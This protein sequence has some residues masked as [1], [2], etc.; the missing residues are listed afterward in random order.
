MQQRLSLVELAQKIESEHRGK[1]D[2]VENT[3]KIEIEKR[4][5]GFD[6]NVDGGHF[7]IRKEAHQQIDGRLHVP[8]GWGNEWREKNGQN[9]AD[10]VNGQ[11]QDAPEVRMI[12]TI[13]G[14]TRAFLSNRYQRIE[15]EEIASVVLPIFRDI[16]DIQ[17]VSAEIT[18]KRLYIQAVTPRVHGDVKVGDRVQAGVTISNSEIGHGAVSIAPLVYRLVCLNGMIIPDKRFRA[19]HVGRKLIDNEALYADDTRQAD[20]KAVLLKVRDNVRAALDESVFATQVAK[21]TAL[22]EGRIEG[23]PVKAI[24][25]LAQKV[26]LDEDDRFSILR[27]LINGGDSSPWGIVNA[28]TSLANTEE[29]Y[30]RSIELETAGGVLLDLPKAEW[31]RVLQAN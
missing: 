6:L 23:D 3:E 27:E 20:D 29:D 10:F 15:N 28:V 17:I 14:E 7:P 9:Y 4:S 1:Q 22:T 8:I 5:V 18:H 30:D 16:P 25:V 2:F 12:R 26:N 24:E 21:M 13:H 19:N 11:F 31:Q